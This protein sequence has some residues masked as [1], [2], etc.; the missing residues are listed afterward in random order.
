M[1][2]PIAHR[3]HDQPCFA[4]YTTV[5]AIQRA[6]RPLL[7]PIGLT[8]PQYVVMLSLWERDGVSVVELSRR[9]TLDSP[10]LTPIL[11]RLQQKGLIART[12]NA[13]DERKLVVTL[14]EAGR[15]LQRDAWD[16]PARMV[17]EVGLSEEDQRVL[18]RLCTG[19][20]QSLGS[21][22]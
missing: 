18:H 2:D 10:M 4:L 5:Q 11:K 3:L 20:Q 17:C 1:A 22:R 12:R 21:G 6:Y 8:Y 14:T 9:T 13:A 16:I 19:I 15:A 7:E